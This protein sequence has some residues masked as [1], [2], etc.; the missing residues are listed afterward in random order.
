M[1]EICD[2]I[3]IFS[4]IKIADELSLKVFK[5]DEYIIKIYE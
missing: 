2:H 4:D 3:Y 5:D 1:I